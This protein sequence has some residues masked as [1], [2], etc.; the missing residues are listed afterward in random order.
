M[1]NQVNQNNKNQ[2]ANKGSYTWYRK[3]VKDYNNALWPFEFVR[4]PGNVKCRSI[5]ALDD[6]FKDTPYNLND[7]K[8][9]Y[10]RYDFLVYYL[11][12]IKDKLPKITHLAIGYSC[13]YYLLEGEIEPRGMVY[14]SQ[15]CNI[16]K[17]ANGIDYSNAITKKRIGMLFDEFKMSKNQALAFELQNSVEQYIN[18]RKNMMTLTSEKPMIDI[19]TNP[20][21]TLSSLRYLVFL[22]NTDVNAYDYRNYVAQRLGFDTPKLQSIETEFGSFKKFVDYLKNG[23]KYKK[24]KKVFSMPDSELFMNNPSSVDMKVVKE[25]FKYISNPNSQQYL[26]YS[27]PLTKEETEEI[28]RNIQALNNL[29]GDAGVNEKREAFEHEYNQIF[30]LLKKMA[31]VLS[32]NDYCYQ[33]ASN[34]EKD[35]W[36]KYL[37]SS[38]GIKEMMQSEYDYKRNNMVINADEIYNILAVLGLHNATETNTDAREIIN[39]VVEILPTYFKD[40]RKTVNSMGI[41]FENIDKATKSVEVIK[42]LKRQLLDAFE[43]FVGC[44]YGILAI[45]MSRFMNVFDKVQAIGLATNLM[46]SIKSDSRKLCCS[47]N[48]LSVAERCLYKKLGFSLNKSDSNFYGSEESKSKLGK[49]ESFCKAVIDEVNGADTPLLTHTDESGSPKADV[50]ISNLMAQY[51]CISFIIEQYKTYFKI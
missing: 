21:I 9:G 10:G 19:L 24:L 30:N 40:S 6:S 2:H 41:G 16:D 7:S 28:D 36:A 8:T 17:V 31:V 45:Y 12:R 32:E 27:A 18:I 50:K 42:K 38:S 4:Q 33:S 35:V 23:N 22:E 46:P 26:Q 43:V 51:D 44:Q 29:K 13:I 5:S 39:A 25:L 37:S 15:L 1:A 11:L 48:I 34:V 20:E 3:E 47:K 49:Y 14:R